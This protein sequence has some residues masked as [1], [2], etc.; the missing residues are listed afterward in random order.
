[1]PLPDDRAQVPAGELARWTA[2]L[3]ILL[4]GLALFA[5]LAP[6]TRPVLGAAAPELVR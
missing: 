3:G 6:A 4:A 2:I 5:W 1:M